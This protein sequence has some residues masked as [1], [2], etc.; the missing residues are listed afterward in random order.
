MDFLLTS[1]ILLGAVVT[2]AIGDALRTRGKLIPHHI[3][4][5]AHVVVFFSVWASS[6][7]VA[8]YAVMY[9]LGRIWAFDLIYNIAAGNK[10]TH[11]GSYSLYDKVMKW[12]TN[13]AR[14]PG[15][16]V[17]VI[18]VMSLTWWLAWLFTR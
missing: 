8:D 2:D 15:H 5:V 16:L 4:E 9:I 12:L 7:F 13:T 1:I 10:L 18:R 6:N 11:I 3:F 14:E 17:W